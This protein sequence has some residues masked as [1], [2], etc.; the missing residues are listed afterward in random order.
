[1]RWLGPWWML[2]GLLSSACLGWNGNLFYLALFFLQ[3]TGFVGLPLV[4]RL[5]ENWNL[6][7]APLRNIRYFVS[8]NLALMEGLFKF[9]GGIKGGAWEP[10][11][12]V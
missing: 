8:M 1:L 9:L 4:D 2:G 12:R 11:Q 5:L 10:P 7:W 6:H 3:L